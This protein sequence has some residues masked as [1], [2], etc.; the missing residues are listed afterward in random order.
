MRFDCATRC[1]NIRSYTLSPCVSIVVYMTASQFARVFVVDDRQGRVAALYPALLQPDALRA[2]M[3]S[4]DLHL[5]RLAG[6]RPSQLFRFSKSRSDLCV[7]SLD[8]CPRNLWRSTSVDVV[9]FPSRQRR[10]RSCGPDAHVSTLVRPA[11]GE[12]RPD[13]S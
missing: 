1:E 6:S 4:A 10:A 9:S 13:R 2:L 8:D 7:S 11:M 3:K 5:I 12:H